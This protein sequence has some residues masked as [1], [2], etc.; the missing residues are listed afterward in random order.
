MRTRAILSSLVFPAILAAQHGSSPGV[1]VD[2]S[3]AGAKMFRA[4]CA[5]CHGLDGSGTGAGPNINS[6][7]FRRGGSDDAIVATISKGVSGTSMPAFSFDAG[8]MWQLVAHIRS[9][10]LVRAAGDVAG[11]PKA[12][13]ALFRTNCAGCHTPAGAFTAPDLTRAASRL[14]AAQLRQSIEDP[15]AAVLPEY[16]SVSG[17][18]KSGQ[19]I[20]G[21]RLN[22]DTSSIQ[23]R[24]RRTG[25]LFSVLKKDLAESEMVRTSPMPAFKGKLSESQI[26]D[27]V[28]FLVKGGG[29]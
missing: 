27:I 11:D 16:W 3:S 1:R 25:R 9:L 14:T 17:K 21:I 22:E 23:L 24:D 20:S 5:G 26:G 2:E 28:A 15:H 19:T 18:T 4:Q 29:Q 8:Q 10:G 13:E 6:G 7:T 12:G